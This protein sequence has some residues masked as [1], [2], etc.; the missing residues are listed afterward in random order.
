M[1]QATGRFLASL[2]LLAVVAGCA[3]LPEASG[4]PRVA[5]DDDPDLPPI[6]RLLAPGVPAA[7]GYLG[8]F[9]Y[10]EQFADAPWIGAQALDLVRLPAGRPQVT[11]ALPAGNSFERWNVSYAAADDPAGSAVMPLGAGDGATIERLAMDPPPAGEWV[12]SVSLWF[13]E[14]AGDATYYWSVEVP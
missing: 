7:A 10:H 9:S 6:A 4:W 14:G 11:V 12:I 8:S 1:V 3:G 13:A 2:A 5:Q